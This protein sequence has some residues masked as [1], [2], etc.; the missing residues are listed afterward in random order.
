MLWVDYHIKQNDNGDIIVEGDKAKE[1]MNK[2]TP[3]YRPGDV[4][5][6]DQEGWLIK[7]PA[8]WV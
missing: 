5:V 4:F 8:V 6:V 1:V 7:Q 3:L 2:E